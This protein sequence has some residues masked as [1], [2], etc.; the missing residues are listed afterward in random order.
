MTV[1][2]AVAAEAATE[3]TEQEDDED[4]DEYKSER[5]WSDSFGW[6]RL[7]RGRE[8]AQFKNRP[9]FLKRV[10]S[11]K[12]RPQH[13][14]G[15]HSPDEWAMASS[16]TQTSFMDGNGSGPACGYLFAMRKTL[17]TEQY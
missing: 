6:A 16:S 11:T 13:G 15:R 9:V 4:N 2:V 17:M 10:C 3:A 8:G 12:P 7:E 5:H 1:A 14:G